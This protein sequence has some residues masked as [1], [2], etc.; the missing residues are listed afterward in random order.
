MAQIGRGEFE[1]LRAAGGAGPRPAG[2]LRA[3]AVR[4]GLLV[5]IALLALVA[6]VLGIVLAAGWGTPGSTVVRTSG[7]AEDAGE[8]D[9]SAQ[10]ATETDEEAAAAEEP[11]MRVHVAGAVA[12]P[13]VYELAP[14]A[15]VCDAVE[16]AGGFSADADPDALNLAAELADGVQVRV[17]VLGEEVQ[18]ASAYAAQGSTDAASSSTGL[19]NVNTATVAEL[20]SL[21]G[22]GPVTAQAIVDEREANGP[23]ASVD[24]L[25]R[26]RGIGDKK[27]A[28]LAGQVCV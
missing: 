11:A 12:S 2:R 4:P 25:T 7:V 24:D 21:S 8:Q 20:E 15:R 22:V 5:A 14:G 17:P 27:L 16:A 19:V 28:T 9:A 3:S 26:V 1:S 23:F 13:G 6:V 10:P 18:E